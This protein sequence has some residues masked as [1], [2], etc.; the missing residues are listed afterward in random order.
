MALQGP[1]TQVIELGSRTLLPGLVEPHMHFV[2]TF[3]DS[4]LDLGP[5][6][7]RSTD[8]VKAKVTAAVASAK[9]GD[10]IL[11]QLF[12]PLITPSDPLSPLVAVRDPEK[13][14]LWHGKRLSKSVTPVGFRVR[15]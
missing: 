14:R 2:F 13:R 7:N 1:K 3:F 6:A 5:F 9:S 12:D 15:G 4:W 11:G 10:W 8:E